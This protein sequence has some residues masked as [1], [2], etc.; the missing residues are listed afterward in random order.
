MLLVQYLSD[1]RSLCGSHEAFCG[2]RKLR[3]SR[4]SE[5]KFQA[6]N[7]KQDAKSK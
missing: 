5:T 4:Y 1:S 7:L 3:R 6:R 2:N